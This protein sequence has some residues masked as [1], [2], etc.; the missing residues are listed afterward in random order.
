MKI[1]W[2]LPGHSTGGVIDEDAL[3]TPL[4]AGRA[5][6]DAGLC[7]RHYVEAVE[8]VLRNSSKGV[9]KTLTTAIDM[10]R[11]ADII[12]VHV[13]ILKHGHFYH[14]ACM[15]LHTED[16][17]YPFVINLAATP[18]GGDCARREFDL[19][20]QLKKRSEAL[21][22]MHVIEDVAVAGQSVVLFIGEWFEGYHE[23]HQTHGDSGD[24]VVVWANGDHQWVSRDVEVSIYRQAAEILTSLYNPSTFEWVQPWHH[25]A[26]DFVVNMDGEFPLVK[27]IT[28]RQYIAMGRAEDVEAEDLL[29]GALFFLVLLSIRNRLDRYDGIGDVAWVGDHSVAASLAGFCDGLQ[30]VMDVGPLQGEFLGWVEQYLDLYTQEDLYETALAVAS[31]FNPRASEMQNIKDGL[32]SHA[33]VLYAAIK[34]RKAH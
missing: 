19:L 24:G 13:A 26:G 12:S 29:E 18:E 11:C 15:T 7:Y 22:G 25:A 21:P 3:D 9:L 28:V 33:A 32:A 17:E 20:L 1:T 27:L 16:R 23:F 8:S 5:S 10:G 34:Q 31:S 6:E 14:P 30:G 4:P 2:S